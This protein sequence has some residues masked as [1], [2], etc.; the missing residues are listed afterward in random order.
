M[1]RIEKTLFNVN[2][3]FSVRISVTLGRRNAAGERMGPFFKR[4]YRSKKYNDSPD[5]SALEINTQDFLVF[6]IGSFKEK[7]KLETFFSYPH[8][9]KLVESLNTAKEWLY[10]ANMF[11]TEETEDGNI[12][13]ISAEHKSTHI[14]VE[15]T[16]STIFLLPDVVLDK[17]G[18]EVVGIR[19]TY[20][21]KE[22]QTSIQLTF[23]EFESLCYFI[24]NFDLSMNCQMMLNC[25]ILAHGSKLI[26]GGESVKVVRKPI[27]KKPIDRKREA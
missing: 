15:S 23:E 10:D 2:K 14:R 27:I 20:E 6:S 24:E 8:L 5:L 21:N 12:L 26:E 4:G 3:F 22:N 9:Y 16:S 11:F 13:V 1:E 25:A 18:Q 7:T 19:I 17:D